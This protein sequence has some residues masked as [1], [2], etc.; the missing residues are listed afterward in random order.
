MGMESFGGVIDYES[1]VD[2]IKDN[3]PT[4]PTIF[5]SLSDMLKD[6][7]SPTHSILEIMK[8]DQTLSMKVLRVAN[9][10]HYRGERQRAAY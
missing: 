6:P 5:E 4:L 3:L 8:S 10:V 1:I 7:N 2:G 9:S